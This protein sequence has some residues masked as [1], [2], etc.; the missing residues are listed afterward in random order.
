M[1]TAVVFILM[2]LAFLLFSCANPNIGKHVDHYRP[3]CSSGSGYE[4]VYFS[5]H[6]YKLKYSYNI[7]KIDKLITFV[8]TFNCGRNTRDWDFS[9]GSVT[10]KFI[11][12]E[13]II[14]EER[15]L[16]SWWYEELCTE[17]SFQSTYPYQ[18][19]FD[20]V[21]FFYKVKMSE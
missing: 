14:L 13:G 10:V 19:D 15:T 20:G 11:S 9:E 7:N 18:D 12:V 17:K 6:D 3:F 21:T 2:S 5:S 16:T 4:T 8:G 1:K